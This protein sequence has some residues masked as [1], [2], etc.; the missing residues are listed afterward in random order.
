MPLEPAG[1]VRVQHG[2]VDVAEHQ[3]QHRERQDVVQEQHPAELERVVALAQAQERAGDAEQEPGGADDDDVELLAGVEA[4]GGRGLAA[5]QRPVR[6]ATQPGAVVAV[7]AVDVARGAAQ[8][9][10]V[11]GEDDEHDRDAEQRRRPEMDRLH[12]R[13]VVDERRQHGQPQHQ[14]RRG[15]R[16]ERQRARPVQRALRCARSAAR[17]PQQGPAQ[18]RPLE[19]PTQ[20][21]VS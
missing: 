11:A 12:E 18:P 2:H 7:E 6:R 17:G 15:Q 20:A 3:R 19:R 16:P 21:S 9:A 4:A 14:P 10:A 13:P 1:R 5:A 8:G